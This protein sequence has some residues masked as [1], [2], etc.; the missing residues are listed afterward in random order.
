MW[1]TFYRSTNNPDRLNTSLFKRHVPRKY[2]KDLPELAT[3]SSMLAEDGYDSDEQVDQD[4]PL[5]NLLTLSEALHTCRSCEL[6]SFATQ[7][8]PGIGPSHAKIMIVGEQPGDH[9]DLAGHPFVGPAGK[10]LQNLAA[11]AGLNLADCYLTNAVKHFR[12]EQTGE[13]RLHKRPGVSHIAACRKWI[14]AEIKL[15]NPSLIICLGATAVRAIIGYP[16]KLEDFMNR[17]VKHP[18]GRSVLITIHPAAVLRAD[19][20]RA[21][22]YAENLKEALNIASNWNAN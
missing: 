20:D 15:V 7:V 10:L 11:G 9:E 5:E 1:R 8:I 3:I 21:Q 22:K 16:L 12:H 13:I 18:D 4:L 14:T 17:I 6:H 2:W 19:V